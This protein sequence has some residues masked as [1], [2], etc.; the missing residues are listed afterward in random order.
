MILLQCERYGIEQVLVN[1]ET[2]A[3]ATIPN[4]PKAKLYYYN[5]SAMELN[6]YCKP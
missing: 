4:P 3:N 2:H 6:K 5:A 1:L